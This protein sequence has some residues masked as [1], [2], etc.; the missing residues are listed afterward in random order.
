[1]DS[2]K[3]A[4]P[5]GEEA[6]GL[7][8]RAMHDLGVSL[9]GDSMEHFRSTVSEPWQEQYP[10]EKFEKAYGSL[11]KA[12]VPWGDLDGLP[13]VIASDPAIDGEGVLELEG[14]YDTRP[15]RIHFRQQWVG[16]PGSRKLL[17]L[18]ISFRDAPA[19][20]PAPDSDAG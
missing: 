20:E 15:Q 1:M 3:K 7:A 10:L 13:M 19:P 14:Y 16:A 8:R 4:V 6:L 11:R 18:Q 5:G 12:K 17:G 9:A 2:Q